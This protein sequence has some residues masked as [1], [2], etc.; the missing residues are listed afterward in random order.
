VTI[1]EKYLYV[2]DCINDRVQILEK[3]NGKFKEQW[4]CGFRKFYYPLSI[5]L[6]EPFIYVGDVNGIQVFSKDENNQCIES[7]GKKGRQTEEFTYVT[8]LCIVNDHLY[9]VDSGNIRIQVWN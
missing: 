3:E 9:I 1:D 2:C 5:L 4:K 8:G 7:F 6:Y